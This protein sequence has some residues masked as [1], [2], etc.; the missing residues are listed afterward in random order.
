MGKKISISYM[1]V[2]LFC[3]I[4][5]FFKPFH[6][7]F[8]LQLGLKLFFVIISLLFIFKHVKMIRAINDVYL[9]SIPIIISCLFNYVDG[10]LSFQNLLNGILYAIGLYCLYTV[11]RYCNSVKYEYEAFC[12]IYNILKLYSLI[13]VISIIV[14]GPDSNDFFFGSKFPSSYI[15]IL[16]TAFCYIKNEQIIKKSIKAK[17]GYILLLIFISIVLWKIGC[18]TG[19]ISFSVFIVLSFV[20]RDIQRIMSKP[21]VIIAALLGSALIVIIIGQILQ[22]GLVKDILVLLGK[23]ATLTDRVRYYQRIVLVFESGNKWL[24]YG[25]ASELMR[26]VIAYGNNIQNGLFQYLL[27]YGIVGVVSLLLFIYKCVK[28]SNINNWG[29]YLFIYTT[30]VTAIV[31]ISIST[32][33]FVCLFSL[34]WLRIKD[35]NSK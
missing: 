15:L 1:D 12:T 2:I 31:E 29:Y 32:A 26:N 11:L 5:P 30:I 3:A 7:P 21:S 4:F 13:T 24:G 28:K 16:T 14:S 27:E 19:T 9:L 8:L 25:Y 10:H 20:S 17:M 34:R 22:L 33:F 18:R 23:D 35:K 6:L